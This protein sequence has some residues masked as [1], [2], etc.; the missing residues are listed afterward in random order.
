MGQFV[1]LTGKRFG[2]LLVIEKMSEHDKNGRLRWRCKCDCENE[3]TIVTHGLTKGTSSCGCLQKEVA[4]DA[5]LVH[6]DCRRGQKKNRLFWIWAGMKNRIFNKNNHAYAAYGG[7]GITVCQEWLE[8]TN[9]KNWAVAN[10]YNEAL[11]LDRID[12]NGDYTPENCRWATYEVQANNSR[13]NVFWEYNGERLTIAQ[14]AKKLGIKPS[15]LWTRVHNHKWS[16][17]RALSTPLI[18]RK[19]KC[20]A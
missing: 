13:K 3:I 6:G 19:G 11:T 2:R 9:F 4:R 7:R 1:D 15:R 18:P 5:H 12:V 16:V 14:W 8:Y 10:G 17:E 20:Y